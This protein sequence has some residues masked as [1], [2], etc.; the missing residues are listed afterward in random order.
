MGCHPGEPVTDL[1]QVI[2]VAVHDAT[3]GALVRV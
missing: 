1:G 2:V 3:V